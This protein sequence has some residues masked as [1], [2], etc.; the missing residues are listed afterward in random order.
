[1]KLIFKRIR[2]F[3]TKNPNK[4]ANRRRFPAEGIA[5]VWNSTRRMEKE[6]EEADGE[7]E[8]KRQ[9]ASDFGPSAEEAKRISLWEEA[10]R[11]LPE[12]PKRHSLT[13]T[14][15]QFSLIV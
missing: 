14:R 1:M 4:Q 6:A 12:R 13:E 5:S 10:C 7:R 9:R 8:K 2:F 11:R 15:F 3:K